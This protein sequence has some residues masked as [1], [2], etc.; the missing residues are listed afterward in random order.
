MTMTRWDRG[1]GRFQDRLNRMFEE[2]Y[3]GSWDDPEPAGSLT[4][5]VPAVDIYEGKDGGLI[6][7]VEVPDV[8]PED[9]DIHIENNI[10]T[11]RGERKLERDV[12]REQYHRIERAYGRFTR[13]FTLPP[14]YDSETVRAEFRDGVLRISVPRSEKA[15]PRQIPVAGA[16]GALPKE[17]TKVQPSAQTEEVPVGSR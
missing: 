13:S 8:K 3:R 4:Q 6:V 5:W 1:I 17:T 10:L 16:S 9:L 15:R 7:K 14:H 11:I 2:A 12:Q